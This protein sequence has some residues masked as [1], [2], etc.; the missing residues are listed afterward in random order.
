M[1][2]AIT[3]EDGH[4]LLAENILMCPSH[5]HYEVTDPYVKEIWRERQALPPGT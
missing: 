1:Q 2:Q 3:S 5:S 4:Q